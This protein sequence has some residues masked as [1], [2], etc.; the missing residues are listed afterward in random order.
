MNVHID[1][2]RRDVAIGYVNHFDAVGRRNGFADTE[3]LTV[4]KKHIADRL[5]ACGGIDNRAVLKQ[6]LQCRYPHSILHLK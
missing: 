1:Q 2:T 6:A 5:L 4:F 3:D